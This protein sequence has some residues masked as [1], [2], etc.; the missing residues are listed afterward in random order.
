MLMSACGTKRTIQLRP[1]LSAIGVTA[2]KGGFWTAMVCPLMTRKRH[3]QRGIVALQLSPM[4]HGEA[5]GDI[6]HNHFGEG[7]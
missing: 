1:R 4:A 7:T 6:M 5:A 3:S 2:D